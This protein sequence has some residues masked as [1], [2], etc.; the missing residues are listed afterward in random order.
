M[1]SPKGHYFLICV[2]QNGP[3]TQVLFSGCVTASS[4]CGLDCTCLGPYVFGGPL[5]KGLLFHPPTFS[6]RWQQE[7]LWA[8]SS[9]SGSLPLAILIGE[10]WLFSMGLFKDEGIG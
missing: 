4:P 10:K 1:L 6:L 7:P 3:E 8:V 9:H 5:G 2:Y